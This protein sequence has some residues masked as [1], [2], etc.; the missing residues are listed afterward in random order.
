MLR[1]G[2]I[3]RA[4]G[5]NWQAISQAKM[6]GTLW[7]STEE[8]ADDN[9]V[10]MECVHTHTHNCYAHTDRPTVLRFWIQPWTQQ[11][12]RIRP[13]SPRCAHLVR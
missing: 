13:V 3:V 8:A 10:D 7:D 6:V 4:V 5:F 9:F 2:K 1:A 11:P 12:L